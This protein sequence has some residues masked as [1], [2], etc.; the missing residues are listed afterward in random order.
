ME[1]E[2]DVF[3]ID[4]KKMKEVVEKVGQP[5]SLRLYSDLKAGDGVI[6]A[7]RKVA[8]AEGGVVTEKLNRM[9]R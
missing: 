3:K 6:D 8:D 9:M 7:T 5:I 4:E 2:D 1:E